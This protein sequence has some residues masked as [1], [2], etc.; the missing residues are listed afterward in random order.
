[1][2]TAT[3]ATAGLELAEQL[4]PDAIILDVMMPD[5][6][7]WELL[8]RL[9]SLPSTSAIPVIICSVFSDPELAFSLG[10]SAV[11]SKPVKQADILETL[12]QLKVV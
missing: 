2:W 6:D 5:M 1:V 3:R 8:Q 7:G 9:R 12:R 4:V 11:L 10:A